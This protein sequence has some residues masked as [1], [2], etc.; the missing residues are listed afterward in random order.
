MLWLLG[1]SKAT[2]GPLVAEATDGVFGAESSPAAALLGRT[3]LILEMEGDSK[4]LISS[5]DG[6][7]GIRTRSCTLGCNGSSFSSAGR[8]S[9]SAS[10]N[11]AQRA[12]TSTL[13]P[14]KQRGSPHGHPQNDRSPS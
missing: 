5:E 2:R 14:T 1:G 10:F 13:A 6:A 7:L 4:A 3:S 11:S 8:K 9:S 12:S